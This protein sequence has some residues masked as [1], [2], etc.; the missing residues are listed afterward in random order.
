[1]QSAADLRQDS[2]AARGADGKTTGVSKAKAGESATL[3]WDVT[4]P[5]ACAPP[6]GA[7][8]DERRGAGAAQEEFRKRK[9]NEHA[10]IAERDEWDFHPACILKDTSFLG[11]G[12]KDLINRIA[13]HRQG[14]PLHQRD[15]KSR[16]PRRVSSPPQ[17]QMRTGHGHCW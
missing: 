12:A 9:D 6:R 3:L 10:A 17:E 1:M 7:M 14:T 4:F 5:S 2:K 8:N 13:G 16:C 15:T 11:Q